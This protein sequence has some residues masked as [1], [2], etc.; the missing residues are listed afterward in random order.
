MLNEGDIHNE[1]L[2]FDYTVAF[3][4]HLYYRVF[5][6]M[7]EWSIANGYKEFHSG[8]LNYDPKWH[9]R[10]ELDPIDLYVRHTSNP[11]NAVFKRLLP[12][13]EPT[14]SDK[15]LRN[16]PNYRELWD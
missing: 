12:L 3:R 6:D 10:Q 5:R 2:G 16:F 4:L 13:M 11:I 7:I 9:L 8:S 14:R 1:Y 15:T